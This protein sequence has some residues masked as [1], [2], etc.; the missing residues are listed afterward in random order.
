MR[1][2][3]SLSKN[4]EFKR[5][6][7]KGRFQRNPVVVTYLLKND[8]RLTRYGITTSKKIGCAVVRNRARRVIKAAFFELLKEE[9][10]KDA[11]CCYDL[12]FVARE[13]TASMK[14]QDVKRIIKRQI[15]SMLEA[16]K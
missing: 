1:S 8:K 9:K 7:Y 14:M 11:L 10:V 15:L 3:V 16:K 6:Y 4:T 12:V 2:C 5:V 13:K